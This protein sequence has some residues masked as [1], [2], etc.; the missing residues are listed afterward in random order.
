MSQ[1]LHIFRK[2]AGRHW[3]EALVSWA[4]IAVFVWYQPRKWTG[5]SIDI[6][7]VATLLNML[8]ALL[9]LS[10]AFLMV[11]LVQGESLV[12]DRQ[13]WITR[14]YEWHKLLLAKLLSIFVF[15]HVP[16]LIGQIVLLKMGH[17]PLVPS[18]WG[19]TQL[20]LMFFMIFVLAALAIGVITSGIGQAALALL[21]VFL[22]ILGI[23]GIGSLVPNSGMSDDA[24]AIQFLIYLAT[25][26]IV[27]LVQFI[28]RKTLLAR[29]IILTSLVAGVLIIVLTPYERIIRHD[30]PLPTGARPLPLHLTFDRSLS[31]AHGDARESG[32]RGDEVEI[33]LPFRVA[34]LSDKSL[35]QIH[36]V[37]LDLVLPDGQQWTSEWK[38]ASLVVSYGRTRTWPAINIEKKFYNKV[39]DTPAKARVTFLYRFFRLG[40]AT[41]VTVEENRT[42][43][44]GDARC[45]DDMSQ[46]WLKCFSALKQPKPVFIIAELPNSACS[47]SKQATAEES[48]AA[49]PATYSVLTAD[50]GAD[51][52]ISPVQ[53]FSV[54]LLRYYF[55][56]DHNIRLPICSGT[57][58]L[59]SKPEFQYAVRDEI[60][61]GD[62]TLANYHPTYPRKVIPPAQKFS[63]ENPANTFSRNFDPGLFYAQR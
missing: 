21:V 40:T 50:T 38:F 37:K 47:V 58:L 20:H 22:L 15:I 9:T 61:L 26:V 29:L 42:V 2:D 24:D 35:V 25:C 43:L 31:F 32:W 14:P 41:T 30:Y 12:G 63:P 51:F 46:N 57:R 49:S 19:L 28:F 3:P 62:I 17:F 56:E 23:A 55:F 33:E 13:F 36:A 27:V 18:L 4:L 10:W 7:F 11:R 16:L 1:V 6:R 8:P 52:D 54:G 5:Q 39:K 44:P 59:V 60:D 48:W 45:V 53:E 34:D